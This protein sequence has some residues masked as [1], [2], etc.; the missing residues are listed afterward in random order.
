MAEEL[1]CIFN[2]GVAT[3]QVS[4]A[5]SVLRR[6]A[7]QW[8]VIYQDGT[9]T[10]EYDDIRPDGRGW[11]ERENKP[12]AEIHLM[13]NDCSEH[14]M[15]IPSG[16]TPVFFRRRSIELDPN[17]S[18]QTHRTVHCIGWRH[19]EQATYL[20]ILPNGSTLLTGDFQAV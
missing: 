5:L 3:G 1:A 18:S 4:H 19:G 6:D 9:V 16:V 8:R 2:Q 15:S 20:F 14:Q 11:A 13:A 12:V 10:D 17:S 7:Y